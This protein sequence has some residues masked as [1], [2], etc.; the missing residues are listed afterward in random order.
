M[1]I[2]I[3]FNLDIDDRKAIGKFYGGQYEPARYECCRDFI[4]NMISAD[5]EEISTGFEPENVQE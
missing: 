2:A 1:K 4:K 3:T 5:I